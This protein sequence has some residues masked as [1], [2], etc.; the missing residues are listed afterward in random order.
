MLKMGLPLDAVKHAMKRDE[1][2]PTIMDLDHDKSVR[3]QQ[4][5][6]AGD[7]IA[8][9]GPALKDDPEYEKVTSEICRCL[10]LV[11]FRPK[12]SHPSVNLS[13]QYFKML[14]MGLPLDAVKHAMKRD[15]KDPAIMDLDH[16]KSLRSQQQDKAGDEIA[17]DGPA[18]KDDP[19][20]E[21]VSG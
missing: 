12:S 17:D 4:Q 9:D 15:E 19:E 7:E 3:S 6:K 21:K 8:D 5:D 10:K 11:A 16:D 1:K 2:D 14:K 20:Y 18:L 13:L